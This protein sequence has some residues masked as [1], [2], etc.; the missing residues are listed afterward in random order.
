[1]LP[2][3]SPQPSAT[4]APLPPEASAAQPSRWRPRV[5]LLTETYHPVVGGGEKQAQSLAE[6]LV[7]RGLPTLV[8]TRRTDR[9]LPP[10]EVLNGV[11]IHRV[12]P[13]GASRAPRWQMVISSLRVLVRARHEFDVVLVAGF[14]AL[15]IPG[16]LA[17]RLFGK[18]CVLKADSNG[19]M[20]GAFFAG[21]LRRIG[22]TPGTP[23]MGA[24]VSMRNII[25]RKAD[26]FVAIT[27]GI[28]RELEDAGVDP[29][30]IRHVTNSVDTTMFC[31]PAQDERSR[32]RSELGLSRSDVVVI[33]T[34]RL[35]TYKGLPR[36]LEVADRIRREHQNVKFVLVGG[37][38]LDMHNCEEDLRRF[39]TERGLGDTV[40][41][42]GEVNDV[43][44]FLQAS[45]IFVLPSEDDA[46][47]LSLVEAMACGLAVVAT[48]VGGI[49]EIVISGE[50]G[51]LIDPGDSRQL[52]NALC[53]LI[54]DRRL[55]GALGTAAARSVQARFSRGR[56][57][58][59]YLELFQGALG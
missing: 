27:N 29:A 3:T 50:N 31:A 17:A 6:D 19:E 39:V 8:V 33:Y 7:R 57:V 58:D 26:R 35:V 9:S 5:C 47:P 48:K 11:R 40:R 41:F 37:G 56:V 15:G 25:L 55:S 34:G 59:Q 22:L 43:R 13:V 10:L 53:R 18:V 51:L 36:L 49:P 46:F 2:T 21:G 14:K 52:H 16:V 28:H 42:A 12:P 45:D 20:S 44:R 54:R 24:F 32:I 30:R 4:H 23:L 1:M 38:G